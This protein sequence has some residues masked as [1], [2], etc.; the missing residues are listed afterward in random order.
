MLRKKI[1]VVT[2]AG[3]QPDPLLISLAFVSRRK[4]ENEANV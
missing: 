4:L 1:G 2:G 3:V